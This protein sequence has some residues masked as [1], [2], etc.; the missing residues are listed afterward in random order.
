MKK[1]LNTR[2]I[3]ADILMHFNNDA[4]PL[5]LDCVVPEKLMPPEQL[6]V[7]AACKKRNKNFKLFLASHYDGKII[8][9]IGKNKHKDRTD[10]IIQ[11]LCQIKIVK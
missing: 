7:F 1:K 6:Q 9:L 4:W 10:Y 5:R 3:V 11:Q 2:S 8:L